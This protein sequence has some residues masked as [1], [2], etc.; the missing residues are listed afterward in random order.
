MQMDELRAWYAS[1]FPPVKAYQIEDQLELFSSLACPMVKLLDKDQRVAF[2]R[3][4]LFLQFKK[5]LPPEQRRKLRLRRAK[6]KPVT[7]PPVADP[8][9]TLF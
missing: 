4:A 5:T 9:L 6:Q 8:V 7:E 3:K 2:V 1:A